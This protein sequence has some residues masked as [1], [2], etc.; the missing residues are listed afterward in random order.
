MIDNCLNN[1]NYLKGYQVSFI[2]TVNIF[3]IILKK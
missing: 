2:E 1:G 3:L